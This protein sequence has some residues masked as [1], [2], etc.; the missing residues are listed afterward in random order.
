MNHVKEGL[1]PPICP[2]E[3]RTTV[4][5]SPEINSP[6]ADFCLEEM[7][8]PTMLSNKSSK[9]WSCAENQILEI[10]KRILNS[11]TAR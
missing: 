1:A 11:C 10:Q 7:K 3:A 5:N 6:R 8:K 9:A 4:V 2:F